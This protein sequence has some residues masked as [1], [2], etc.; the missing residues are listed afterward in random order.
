MDGPEVRPPGHVVGG[1]GV[2]VGM[3]GDGAGAE[4]VEMTAREVVV[5]VESGARA[6]LTSAVRPYLSS[7]SRIRGT[8]RK[9][10]PSIK[11]VS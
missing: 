4:D 2:A 10:S 8:S 7:A 6:K 11:G 3:V 1:E 5:S 9:L